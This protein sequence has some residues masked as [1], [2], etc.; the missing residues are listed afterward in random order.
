[1]SSAFLDVGTLVR[2]SSAFLVGNGM[3]SDGPIRMSSAF[4]V[5]NVML[6]LGN[7]RRSGG[8]FLFLVAM[9]VML[10]NGRRPWCR[11]HLLRVLTS[12]ALSCCYGG[13]FPLR[14]EIT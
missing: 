2:M 12:C 9:N 10:G 8:P 3:L 1:M 11:A 4:L 13:R 6:S 5:G 14:Q 7:G